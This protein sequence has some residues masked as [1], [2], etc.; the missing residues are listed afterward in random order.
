MTSPLRYTLV[1]DGTSDRALMPVLRWLLLQSGTKLPLSASWAD[2]RRLQAKT[3]KLIDRLPRAL[4]LYP[5]DLLFVHRDAEK[6]AAE[7]R[8]NEIREALGH[9]SDPPP[10][11]SVVPVRMTEAW[12]LI[13]EAAIRHAVDNPNGVAKL[14]L[15]GV[16]ELESLSDPKEKLNEVLRTACDLNG[17][18][19]A[20]FKRDESVRRIR[21]AD[22]VLDYSPL[23]LLPAFSRLQQETYS[24]LGQHNWLSQGS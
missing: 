9:L 18:R 12:L 19:L 16:K 4:D 21:V 20:Q 23:L 13:D 14:S 24:L 17:R 11:I 15:P 6:E 22:F 5:C 2:P 10:T 3:N 1:G 8:H 7:A